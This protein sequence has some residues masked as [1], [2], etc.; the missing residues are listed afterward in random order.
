[1]FAYCSSLS[2][3]NLNSFSIERELDS[4]ST[5]LNVVTSNLEYVIK[6]I[7]TVNHFFGTLIH[8]CSE[9]CSQE[10]KKFDAVKHKCVES[11][12]L[13]RFEF[14]N[15]CYENCPSNTFKLFTNRN[16]CSVKVPEN[17]YLDLNDSIYKECYKTCKKCNK[18]GD[19]ESNNCDQC[20][21][22]YTFINESF[23]NKNN[24]YQKCKNYY[25]FGENKQYICTEKNS[26]PNN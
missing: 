19:E 7:F 21:D 5:F 18:E 9:V 17:F 24:C 25:Y 22:N 20:I 11:C 8:N 23:I 12:D 3:L 26:C 4:S 14:D 6:D 2:Y 1:M 16:I 15:V 13:I 10:H